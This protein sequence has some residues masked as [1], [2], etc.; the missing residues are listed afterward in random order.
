MDSPRNPDDLCISVDNLTFRYNSI[1]VLNDISFTIEYGKVLGFLGFNG[2][3]KTTTV[4]IL[5]TLLKPLSG[6]VTVFGMDISKHSNEIKERIGVVFQ[7]PSFEENLTVKQ[8]L[9]VYGFLWGVRKDQRKIKVEQLLHDFDLD[10]IK[11]MNTSEL[12]IGQKR[13]VQVAREFMHEMDLIFLDEPTVGLDPYARRLLLDYIRKKVSSGLTV[14]FT[15]HI[16]EEAEY[17]CD[18]IA[19]INKGKII[20]VDTPSA[21]KE[22]HGNIKIIEVKL[23]CHIN[24]SVKRMA[25]SVVANQSVISFPKIDIIKINSPDAQDIMSKMITAF[26]NYNILVENI[27]VNSPSLEDVFLTIIR[28]NQPGH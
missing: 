1:P 19:I 21:L 13:R 3:G 2:A 12:S 25:R 16:M 9:D 28:E 6:K 4:K 23:G 7:H 18:E 22:R 14:F 5:S 20:T 27:S 10:K 15:T 11:N 17:L 24:E 8:A 26:S